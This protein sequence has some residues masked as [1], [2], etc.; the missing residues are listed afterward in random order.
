MSLLLDETS[1]VIYKT[2]INVI[3]KPFVFLG[4]MMSSDLE[5]MVV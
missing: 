2:F 4:F 1:G 5:W 3:L